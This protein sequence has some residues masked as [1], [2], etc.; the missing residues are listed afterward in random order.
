MFRK[1]I[2]PIRLRFHSTESL[3]DALDMLERSY[4]GPKSSIP[5]AE[6]ERALCVIARELIRRKVIFWT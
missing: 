1:L 6:L 5:K 3:L 2:A 4:T